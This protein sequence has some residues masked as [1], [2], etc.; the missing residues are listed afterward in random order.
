M[1]TKPR[2]TL[3]L[4]EA[5]DIIVKGK[6]IFGWIVTSEEQLVKLNLGNK[7]EHK[8]V[9]INAILLSVFQAHI[10][11]V[12]MEYKDVFAWSYKELKGI[13]REVCEHKIEL[14]VNVQPIKQKQYRMNPNYPLKV[15]EDLDKLLDVE[16][17]YTIKT[18]H[19]LSPLVIMLKKNGKLC[20]IKN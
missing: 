12:L 3:I 15:R 5:I 13:P 18:T 6:K 9:L 14:M 16:F 4:V 2:E 10:K 1:N 20:I 11:K 7:E 8:E 17:I 19:W